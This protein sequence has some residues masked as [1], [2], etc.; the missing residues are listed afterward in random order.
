MR[1]VKRT[2]KPELR[3]PGY[4]VRWWQR[5]TDVL[6]LLSLVILCASCA[7]PQPPIPTPPIRILPPLNLMRVEPVPEFEGRTYGDLLEYV[8][9]LRAALERANARMAGLFEWRRT[10]EEGM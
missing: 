7:T 6:M 1:Y 8:P 5:G 3:G 4:V 2:R 9:E 10:Q